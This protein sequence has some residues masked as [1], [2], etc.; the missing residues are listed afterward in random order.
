[1]IVTFTMEE[2]G[3]QL[4]NALVKT[5]RFD[6]AN[7]MYLYYALHEKHIP[8]VD[9]AM[10]QR[11]LTKISEDRTDLWRLDQKEGILKQPR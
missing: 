9:K 6:Y 2:S 1:M 11:G 5:N 4:F 3:N 7:D 8:I 10:S